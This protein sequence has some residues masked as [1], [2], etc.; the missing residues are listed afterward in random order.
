MRNA[1]E[2]SLGGAN[3]RVE[4]KLATR[5]SASYTTYELD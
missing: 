3:V 2:L 1:P 4:P 5:R